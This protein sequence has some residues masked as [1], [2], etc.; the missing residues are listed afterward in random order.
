MSEFTENMQ[1]PNDPTR[2]GSPV[3]Q[4]GSAVLSQNEIQAL[5]LKAS[6]GAGMPWGLAEE[7]G[8]AAAWL[9]A[10]GLDGP[11]TLLAQLQNAT[12]K[13]WAEICPV[14]DTGDFLPSENG[15]MCPIALGAALCDFAQLPAATM[16]TNAIAVGPV[17]YPL[18]LLPFLA[19]MAKL[20][21]H[22]IEFRWD[23]HAV[24]V[25]EDGRVGGDIATL[26]NM[27][28]L[29]GALSKDRTDADMPKPEGQGYPVTKSTLGAL[30]DFAM[31]TT[32]PATEASRADAGAG[33]TD[34]D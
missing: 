19:E 11:G 26:A 18:L 3:P 20:R 27:P 10:R 5:C 21:H 8:F 25:S 4:D 22:A 33:E 14:V 2:S 23:M 24:V 30:N 28:K 15:E 6:R 9:A 1:E 12:G 17:N 7:A 32:V 16:D 34:N 13:S 29:T 31:C